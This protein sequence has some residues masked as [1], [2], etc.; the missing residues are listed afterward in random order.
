[1]LDI[2]G[3]LSCLMKTWRKRT[4]IRDRVYAAGE[5]RRCSM[6]VNFVKALNCTWLIA[7]GE[8][9]FS[10]SIKIIEE[11]YISLRKRRKYKNIDRD[12]SDRTMTIVTSVSPILCRH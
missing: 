9:Y 7:N 11:R 6:R 8:R 2:S 12:K 1:M 4:F 5:I 10:S 3:P